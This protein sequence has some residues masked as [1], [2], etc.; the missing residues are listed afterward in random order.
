[1]PSPPSIVSPLA[2]PA[3]E[4]VMISSPLPALI[5]SFPALPSM[6]S[7]PL[8]PSIVSLLP[9]PLRVSLPDRPVKL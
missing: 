3:V 8:P 2:S 5:I 7:S 1:M 9:F 6:V 4:T